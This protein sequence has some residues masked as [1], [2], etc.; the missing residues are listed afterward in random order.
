MN[1]LGLFT[2]RDFLNWRN[3]S[4]IAEYRNMRFK[5]LKKC[6]IFSIISKKYKIC[7]G[8]LSQ[9]IYGKAGR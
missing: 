7:Q 2:I 6:V 9:I 4:I 1:G 8:R 5:K 3:E